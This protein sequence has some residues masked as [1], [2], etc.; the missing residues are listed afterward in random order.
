MRLSARSRS[1]CD[2]VFE[3]DGSLF[4]EFNTWNLKPSL[5]I[6]NECIFLSLMPASM[7]LQSSLYY[8]LPYF[9]NKT[10]LDLEKQQILLK[11]RIPSGYDTDAVDVKETEDRL[12]IK[13]LERPGQR[14][15]SIKTTK[16]TSIN[17]LY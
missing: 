4:L 9:Q 11:I 2:S 13:L 5:E 12:L 17:E 16:I 10:T 6:E 8:C 1:V 15:K 14:R 3:S 7:I